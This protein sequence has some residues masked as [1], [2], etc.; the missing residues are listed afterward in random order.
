MPV[1]QLHWIIADAERAVTAE[2]VKDGLKIYEN[3]VGVLAN[4]PPFDMQLINLSNYMNLSPR[5]PGNNFSDKIEL[6]KYSRGMGAMGLAGD[7][8]SQS[9]FVRAAFVKLNSVSGDTEE[10]SVN[11]F[12]HILGSVSQPRGSC[13]VN[14]GFEITV[15]TSCCNASKG[16]Y[17]YTTYEDHAISAV[18]MRAEN[19]DGKTLSRYPLS[20]RESI[21]FHN[22]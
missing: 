3:R 13:A 11:Q 8:S 19:L 14:G 17:Y 12:F 16:V 7:W 15:Y 1:A 4:N 5:D 6:T 9:R 18:D 10:E 20:R 22:R 2:F 21:T